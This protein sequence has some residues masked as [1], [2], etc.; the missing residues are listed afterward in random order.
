MPLRAQ[1]ALVF[2][3]TLLAFTPTQSPAPRKLGAPTATYDQEFTGIDGVRELKDG[4]VVV[5]DAREQTIHVIDLKTKSETRIGRTGDGPGEFRLPLEIFP[6]SGDSAVIRDMGRF[7]KVMVLTPQGTLG[8]FIPTV[9]SALNARAFEPAAA[10]NAGRFYALGFSINGAIDSARIVRWDRE[11]HTR[12][13]LALLSTKTVS[14]LVTGGPPDVIRDKDG[15]AIGYRPGPIL[16]FAT[17]DQWAVSPDGRIATVQ[18]SPYRVTYVNANGMRT[19]GP[20][21][22][23]TPVPVTEADRAAWRVE[24]AQP[25]PSVSRGRDGTMTT[26]FR[27]VP[28]SEPPEWEPTLPAFPRRSVTFGSD[29]M[30]WVRRSVSVGAPPRYDVFD[31]GG[32]LSYQLE[33][34]AKRKVVGFGAGVVYVARVDD[35]DLHYLERYKLPGR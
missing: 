25:R 31:A 12:D 23:F 11:K 32:R 6:I 14:P 33:L 27:K 18:A 5:L 7:G 4:R 22:A 28:I 3:A 17:N 21:N 2:A 20:I 24:A 34:P 30:L 1:F 10:D 26:S 8:D 16:P 29:G 13:T 9:D 15:R 35:D 19:A